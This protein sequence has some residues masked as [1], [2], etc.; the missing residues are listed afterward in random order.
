LFFSEL[1]GSK[2]VLRLL[3]TQPLPTCSFFEKERIPST[4]FKKKEK[5]IRSGR[6]NPK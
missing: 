1:L 5:R 4:F 3:Y 6:E 2:P